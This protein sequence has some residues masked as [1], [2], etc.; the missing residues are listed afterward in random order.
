MRHTE[1]DEGGSLDD[2]GEGRDGD[3]VGREDDVREVSLVL[4][5]LVHELGEETSAG[6]LVVK[7]GKRR[8]GRE[9]EGKERD[10]ERRQH[11]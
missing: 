2:F 8:R 10:G 3:E 11:F 1:D 7:E 6:N 9:G 4:V 5:L